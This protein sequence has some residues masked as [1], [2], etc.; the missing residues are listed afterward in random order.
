MELAEDAVGEAHQGD[1]SRSPARGLGRLEGG[2]EGARVL[3]EG[4]RF[5]APLHLHTRSFCLLACFCFKFFTTL[6]QISVRHAMCAG[7]A[8]RKHNRAAPK[9]RQ[10]RLRSQQ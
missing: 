4:V 2:T 1:T 8:P 9:L 6:P 10:P 7:R 3:G 5:H